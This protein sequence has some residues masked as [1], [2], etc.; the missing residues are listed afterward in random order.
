MRLLELFEAMKHDKHVLWDNGTYFIAG[1]DPNDPT[2][3]TLWTEDNERIGQLGTR[4]MMRNKEEWL[5]VAEVSVKKAY[6]GERLAFRMYQ[7]LLANMPERYAGLIGYQPDIVHKGVHKIYKRLGARTEDGDYYM[8]PNPNRV[9]T[10]AREQH[11][12]VVKNVFHATSAKEKFS[13]LSTRGRTLFFSKQPRTADFG[14]QVFSGD[15]WF[16]EPFMFSPDDIFTV[17]GVMSDEAVMKTIMDSYGASSWQEVVDDD[18]LQGADLDEFFAEQMADDLGYW[19][20][21]LIV[22]AMKQAGYDG[23]I[24]NDPFGG[25]VEFI[26]FNDNQFVPKQQYTVEAAPRKSRAKYNYWD[27]IEHY[28]L[29]ETADPNKTG[30]L[31]LPWINE[32]RP[33]NINKM[34]RDPNYRLASQIK[35]YF[36]HILNVQNFARKATT[37]EQFEAA[38][39]TPIQLWRGGGGDY[40]PARKYPRPWTSFTADKR[41]VKTFSQYAGTHSSSAFMLPERTRYWEVELTI[42]LKDMLLYV[43]YGN[44]EEVLVST[45]DAK[46]AQLITGKARVDGPVTESVHQVYDTMEVLS[47]MQKW[48]EFFHEMRDAWVGGIADFGQPQ[49]AINIQGHPDYDK[50]RAALSDAVTKYLGDPFVGYRLMAE[51]QIEEWQSGADMPAM[52]VSID[53]RV[54]QAFRKFASNQGRDDLRMVQ[55]SVPA[56]AIIM[57][58]HDGEQELVV[59]P[60]W[61]SANEVQVVQESRLFKKHEQGRKMDT[62]VENLIKNYA[63]AEAPVRDFEVDPSVNQYYHGTWNR[64]DQAML[65]QPK[66]KEITTRRI[67]TTIPIDMHFAGLIQMDRK[68]KWMS[69]TNTR[70]GRM[71]DT[72]RQVLQD[73]S[74]VTTAKAVSNKWGVDIKPASDAI[75]VLYLSNTNDV[76]SAIPITPWIMTHRLGHSLEDAA[77]AGQLGTEARGAEDLLAN[78]VVNGMDDDEDSILKQSITPFLTMKS[79]TSLKLDEGEATPEMIAQYLYSGKVRLAR[80]VLPSGQ[81]MIRLS[82]GLFPHAEIPD[83]DEFNVLIEQEEQRINQLVGTIVKGAI[84]LLVVAP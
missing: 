62:V 83:V 80:A 3:L 36:S 19:Q 9:V 53:K 47:Q 84:G 26:I 25:S 39:D 6:Q 67:K 27:L 82:N 34:V 60:N 28:G 50:Y 20:N 11:E 66:M 55:L 44:D 16:D 4:M 31:T 8:V 76:E 45:K 65:N 52:A 14:K 77:R 59:D 18:V 17:M 40:D 38:L 1:N 21:P 23:V 33:G 43:S 22:D 5:G 29:K 49:A 56:D 48:D 57:L 81:R 15:I 74:G 41:R 63:I 73:E 78:S 68:A 51:D 24:T 2:F 32:N 58:G 37:P 54:A 64:R 70:V 79:A 69:S 7:A 13:N 35:F 72:F 10:E 12:M 42:P 75:T 46:N 71:T 30:D 61:I